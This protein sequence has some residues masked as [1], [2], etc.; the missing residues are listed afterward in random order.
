MARNEHTPTG[1]LLNENLTHLALSKFR[2]TRMLINPYNPKSKILINH[3]LETT[4]SSPSY[5]FLLNGG[6][7]KEDLDL[8]LDQ[9]SRL[10]IDE[11]EYI[12]PYSLG[13]SELEDWVKL[14]VAKIYPLIDSSLNTSIKNGFNEHGLP[15]AEEISRSNQNLLSGLGIQDR[16]VMQ[17]SVI[18]ALTHDLGNF[19]SRENHEVASIF[20]LEK[21]LPELKINLDQWKLIRKA[22]LFHN[23][24][25]LKTL[26]GKDSSAAEKINILRNNL[27]PDTLVLILSDKTSVGRNRLTTKTIDRLSVNEDIHIALNLLVSGSRTGFSEDRQAFNWLIDFSAEPNLVT[28]RS[29]INGLFFHH[30]G[31]PTDGSLAFV[32]DAWH[33]NHRLYGIPHIASWYSSFMQTYSNRLELAILSSFAL[34]PDQKKFEICVQEKVGEESGFTIKE[35]IYKDDIDDYLM[36]LKKKFL[37]KIARKNSQW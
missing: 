7:P 1:W 26:W 37:P 27:C 2:S 31:Q 13:I 35:Q 28:D 8:V 6:V 29:N 23:I 14:H 4:Q 36:T 9:T 21:V 15:H 30:D 5:E 11:M 10:K 3:D 16:Q 22:I 12:N 20:L 24:P 33:N 17:R 19:I 25:F 18:E 34:N 32:P